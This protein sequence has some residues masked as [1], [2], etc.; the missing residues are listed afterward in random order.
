MTECDEDQIE[1][2]TDRAMEFEL[3]YNEESISLS[4]FIESKQKNEDT[5]H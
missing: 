2:E 1:R 3:F 4:I 5:M